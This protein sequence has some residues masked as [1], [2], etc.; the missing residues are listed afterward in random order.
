MEFLYWR[1]SILFDRLIKSDLV[2]GLS[3]ATLPDLKLASQVVCILLLFKL[4]RPKVCFVNFL[5]HLEKELDYLQK[6]H[7]HIYRHNFLEIHKI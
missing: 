7:M 2:Y 5:V 4:D 1:Q 6:V 3:R